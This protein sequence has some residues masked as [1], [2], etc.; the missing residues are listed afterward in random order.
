VRIDL[1]VHSSMSDGTDRPDELPSRARSAGL[2]VFA[3]TDHDTFEGWP[4]ATAAGAEAGVVVVPGVEI[5][6]RLFG[7]GVHLLGYLPD[8]AHA[9]LA[10]ELARVRDSRARRL[11]EMTRL[12]T[13]AGM[14]LDVSDVLSAA[15]SAST[16]GRPHVADAM[17]AKG[18]IGDRAEAFAD[19]LYEGGPAYVPR[20]ALATPEAIRLVRA[21][22]GV[23]VLAHPWGRGSRRVLDAEAIAALAAAGLTGI[24][25]DHE[26]HT[27]DDR[28]ALRE[29]AGSLGLVVTGSSDHHGTGK[30]GHALGVNTT[31]P[32]E[33]ERLLERGRRAAAAAGREFPRLGVA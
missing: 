8:P 21:A 28:G 19:W 9:P 32:A 13:E 33:Y 11:T 29:I 14:P 15:G 5:S 17:V 26:D 12:L 7:S 6:T 18:Y 4:S 20:Y 31:E 3:L 1:H 16:L 10:D 2:D 27:A 24:E 25:V 30:A 23:S 22:G